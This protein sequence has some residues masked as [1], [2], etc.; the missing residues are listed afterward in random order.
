MKTTTGRWPHGQCVVERGKLCF[1]PCQSASP[2]ITGR[3]ERPPRFPRGRRVALV[4][5][6]PRVVTPR[7]TEATRRDRVD[8]QKTFPS[9]ATAY[10]WPWSGGAEDAP[11]RVVG[12]E[13]RSRS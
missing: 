9:R 6:R 3:R 10:Q 8:P 11:I 5:S 1:V 2:L 7:T 12:I 13:T 4:T